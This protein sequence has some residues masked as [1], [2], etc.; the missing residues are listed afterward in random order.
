MLILRGEI[1]KKREQ[2]RTFELEQDLNSIL[3]RWEF[4]NQPFTDSADFL[5]KFAPWVG[6]RIKESQELAEFLKKKGVKS[7]AEIN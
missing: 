5:S 3:T 6:E 1:S 7:L 4:N 2:K